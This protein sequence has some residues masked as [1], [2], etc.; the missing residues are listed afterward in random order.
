MNKR[1]VV[2]TFIAIA[3]LS[4]IL[5]AFLI[6]VANKNTHVKIQDTTVR[7]ETL[8]SLTKS[9]GD[10]LIP[11]AI[12]SSSNRA[13][14]SW[15]YFLDHAN[16]DTITQEFLKT[17]NVNLNDNLKNALIK[18][19]YYK[20]LNTKLPLSYMYDNKDK[21]NYTLPA[22][23]NELSNLANGSGVVFSY[24]DPST[25]TFTITQTSPWE[26]N[27]IVDIPRYEVS[28]SKKNIFWVFNDRQFS[29]KLNIENYVDPF[30][31][32]YDNRSVTINKTKITNFNIPQDFKNFYQR[33]EFIAHNDAPNFLSRIQGK[34]DPNINGIETVLDP[35]YFPNPNKYSNVDFQYWNRIAGC[36]VTD[37]EFE[38]LYL[39]KGHDTLYSRTVEAICEVS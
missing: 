39:T 14:L 24:D 19:S 21:S 36:L 25:Y 17:D 16:N 26:I 32:V 35:L 4:V 20:D 15:L 33:P 13:I 8:N 31:L 34:F 6:N 10:E 11:E 30:M 5:I 37:P 22:V 29:A 1:A 2:F 27:V 38:D 23:L 7:I 28:D 18:E 3:L 12:R 9:L